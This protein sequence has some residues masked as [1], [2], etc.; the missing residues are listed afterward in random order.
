MEIIRP[1]KKNLVECLDCGSLLKYNFS[2]VFRELDKYD[3][4]DCEPI[5]SYNIRCPCS[6]VID[7]SWEIPE[8]IQDKVDEY[9]ENLEKK[10]K[11]Y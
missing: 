10:I 9:Y 1:G 3:P 11:P 4:E 5:Y 6:N 8:G 7:V 2:D